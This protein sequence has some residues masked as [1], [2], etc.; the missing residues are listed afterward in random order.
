[1]KSKK[2]IKSE[3]EHNKNVIRA[4]SINYDRAIDHGLK[5]VAEHH[6]EVM[7]DYQRM[8]RVLKWVMSS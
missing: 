4:A 6:K 5:G 2:E 3:I 7:V 1:M 8:N